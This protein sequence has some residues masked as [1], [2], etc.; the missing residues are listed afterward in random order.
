MTVE[1]NKPDAVAELTKACDAYE[2]ALMEN[3]LDAMDALFWE[4][5]LTLRYGV[6][7]NLHGIDEIRDFRKGRSGG[8]PRRDVVR[9]EIVTFGDDMGTCNLV[10]QRVGGD[11]QG[12]QSQTWMKTDAGWKV[13]SA[14]VSLMGATS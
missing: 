2:K 7:E 8:S 1:I 11:R 6:G 12:R 5:P 9:R 14:H 4:S 13:V 10:F 3:D